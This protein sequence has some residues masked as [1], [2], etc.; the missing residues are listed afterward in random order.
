MEIY[1][2]KG[3][4][5]IKE[6]KENG[7]LECVISS[8]DNRRTSNGKKFLTLTITDGTDHARIQIWGN[9][10]EE[11]GADFF[12]SGDGMAMRV[13]YNEKYKSFNLAKDYPIVHLPKK[14]DWEKFQ[15][16]IEDTQ[17]FPKDDMEDDFLGE[18]E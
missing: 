9:T 18:F 17:I 13:L 8:V 12:K 10:I 15:H 11:Y 5:N 6:A 16:Y 1:S 4:H 14:S 2:Y 7:I 3:G